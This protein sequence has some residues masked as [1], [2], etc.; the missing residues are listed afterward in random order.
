MAARSTRSASP[1]PFY[2]LLLVVSTA[3][4]LSVL[5]YLIA[6]AVKQQAAEPAAGTQAP[7]AGS[8]ALAS[9]IE[10]NAP[11]LIAV[12]LGL[13]IVTGLLAILLEQF[14]SRRRGGSSPAQPIPAHEAPAQRSD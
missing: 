6:P 3:F 10:A 2:V 13:M 7:S 5:A 9:W 4:V 12:E 11:R 14:V 1:N 8:V